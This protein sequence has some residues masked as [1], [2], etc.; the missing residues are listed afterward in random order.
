MASVTSVDAYLAA[1]PDDRRAALSEIRRAVNAAAP[2]ATETIAY[3]MPAIRSHGGQFLVSYAAFKS[4]YS[5]FPASDAVIE[6]LRDEVAPYVAGKG[7][8]RFPA[9]Q[10]IP[11]DTITKIVKIR[12]EELAAREVRSGGG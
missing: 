9:D 11:V 3:Q 5:L 7:T 6:A 1:L 8:L 12:L 2:E 10:P 4:H